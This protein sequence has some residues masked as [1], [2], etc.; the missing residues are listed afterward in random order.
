MCEDTTQLVPT[1]SDASQ[2][3][4]S[5]Q[6]PVADQ[7]DDKKTMNHERTPS[8]T[9]ALTSMFFSLSFVYIRAW[10]VKFTPSAPLS[11]ADRA[12][13]SPSRIQIVCN[14]TTDCE[15]EYHIIVAN[16]KKETPTSKREAG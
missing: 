5:R 1:I 14:R 6:A 11:S 4:I 2:L 8:I 16:V 10:V 12:P 9:E 3:L 15:S 7:F 13:V